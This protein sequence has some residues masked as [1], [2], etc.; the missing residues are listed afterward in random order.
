MNSL[1]ASSFNVLSNGAVRKG[2]KD[3]AVAARFAVKTAEKKK[4]THKDQGTFQV[5][6]QVLNGFLPHRKDDFA[7][8][9]FR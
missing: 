6:F 1:T 4:N 8:I 2:S 9:S 3:Y 5:N 7:K